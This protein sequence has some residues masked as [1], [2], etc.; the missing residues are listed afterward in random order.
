[1]HLEE[2]R[3]S[4]FDLGDIENIKLQR[5]KVIHN[6]IQTLMYIF[7]NIP[8]QVKKEIDK[9]VNER[10]DFEEEMPIFKH[11]KPPEEEEGKLIKS[12]LDIFKSK[13]FSREEIEYGGL[14]FF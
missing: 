7:P 13:K 4:F 14:G 12:K 2:I 10:M 1:M 11:D 9:I 8:K 6:G 3:N 5:Q